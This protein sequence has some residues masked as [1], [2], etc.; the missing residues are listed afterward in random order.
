MPPKNSD[1]DFSINQIMKPR[2]FV[3]F[4]GDV[5]RVL[6]FIDELEQADFKSSLRLANEHE[7]LLRGRDDKPGILT[8]IDRIEGVLS[9]VVWIVTL[10]TATLVT[11]GIGFIGFLLTHGGAIFTFPGV[12]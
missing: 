12:K 3:E 10:V 1:D 11:G 9:I 4:M 6:K 2:E 8:R 7:A 5:K